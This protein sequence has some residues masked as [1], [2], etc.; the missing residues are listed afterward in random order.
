MCNCTSSFALRAPRNDGVMG[1]CKRDADHVS[2]DS[3]PLHWRH[4]PASQL[5]T[6]LTGNAAMNA[7]AAPK[8][9]RFNSLE[10]LLLIALFQGVPIFASAALIK[11][12][13]GDARTIADKGFGVVMFVAISSLVFALIT[14]W[15]G[16]K[17]PNRFR[18]LYE[19]LFFDATLSFQ[20][21]LIRWRTQPT[22]SLQLLTT[23]IMM[24]LLAVAA[25]SVG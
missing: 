5:G 24:S 11:K 13:I 2:P 16:P 10:G 23:V 22:V 14:A 6:V 19:P 1:S 3:P 18:K 8:S 15:L 17:F 7:V 9:R 20:E 25:A 12:A 4:D 21:K